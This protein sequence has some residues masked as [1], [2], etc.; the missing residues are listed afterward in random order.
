MDALNLQ[1][2]FLLDSVPPGRFFGID[3]R[4]VIQTGAH[5]FSIA[6]VGI[7]LTY[8]LYNPVRNFLRERVERVKKQLDDARESKAAA[9]ELRA[10][11]DRHL[12]D[13]ELERTAIL[14]E[15]RKLAG[16][17]R[18]QI[19]S[20]AKD[21]AKELKDRAGMEITAE[22]ERVR[23]EIHSAVID[24]SSDIAEKL[25]AAAIDKDA[26]ERLFAEGLAELDRVI[27]SA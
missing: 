1:L 23:D 20:A 6:V 21:E 5:L 4:T 3:M 19:L 24:I 13:I 10:R 11:Y 25:L 9:S 15:A 26:H 18:N 17:Q 7:L 14:E 22:R 8:I 27:F 12:K 2:I 16:E